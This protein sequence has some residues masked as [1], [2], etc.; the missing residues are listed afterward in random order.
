MIKMLTIFRPWQKKVVP[1][2]HF[3]VECARIYVLE[4]YE[5]NT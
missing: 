4:R 5:E 2:L 1:G 3:Q